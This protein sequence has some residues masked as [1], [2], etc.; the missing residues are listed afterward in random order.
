MSTLQA[1][2]IKHNASA[3]N[4]ITLSSDGRVGIGTGTPTTT[5]DVRSSTAADTYVR[6]VHP[7]ATAG[8]DVGLTSGGDAT[9]FN[10]NNTSLVIGTNNAER[11]RVAANGNVGIAT[12]A[13][14]QALDV[15]GSAVV[16]GTIAMSSSFL[17]NRIINGDMRIDQRYLGASVTAS[18]SAPMSVD[19]FRINA[20]GTGVFTGQRSTTA[21]PSFMNSLQLQVTSSDV[22]LATT[23]E[24]FIYQMIEGFNFAD[25]QFGTAGALPVTI[26][27]WVRSSLT[28]SFGF[29]LKNGTV[30]RTYPTSYT[31]NTANTWE[32]KT[33]TIPGDTTG[34]WVTNNGKGAECHWS[35]GAAAG[36]KTTGNAWAAGNF[37]SATGTVNWISTLGATFFLTGV[38]LE[39]GT[40]ATP[41]ERRHYGQELSLCQRYYYGTGVLQQVGGGI[42]WLKESM[43]A[44]PTVTALGGVSVSNINSENFRLI[45]NGESDVSVNFGADAELS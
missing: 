1:T 18:G 43:R 12:S 32:F 19:R 24:Y 23:D 13:P 30:A 6:T 38:Q 36:F 20:A 34:T 39:V 40:V 26:S 15:N 22:V 44:A 33:I 4:N 31:I 27:F 2:N 37:D 17:R 3:S 5:L 29:A 8:Y 10:R 35:L 11:V 7:S 25:F 41:F 14:G 42:V 28:G 21:P 9:V 16:S 45:N